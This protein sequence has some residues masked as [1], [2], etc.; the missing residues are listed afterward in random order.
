M[1]VISLAIAVEKLKSMQSKFQS[2]II[3]LIEKI[4][5][6]HVDYYIFIICIY[7]YINEPYDHKVQLP[8]LLGDILE[9]D[10]MM[11]Y[12]IKKEF[13]LGNNYLQQLKLVKSIDEDEFHNGLTIALSDDIIEQLENEVEVVNVAPKTFKELIR[14]NEKDIPTLFYNDDV[15]QEIDR[16]KKILEPKRFKELNDIF[17]LNYL[18]THLNILLAGISGSGKSE[19]AKLLSINKLVYEVDVSNWKSSFYGESQKIVQQH[20]NK[21]RKMAE[22]NP[23]ECVMLLN[24][25]DALIGKRLSEVSAASDQTNN[26]I[27]NIILMNIEKLGNGAILIATTNKMDFLDEAF[28]RRFMIK[29]NIGTPNVDTSIKIW[30]HYLSGYPDNLYSRLS[31]LNLSGGLISIICRKVIM[32]KLVYS[33]DVSEDTIYSWAFAESDFSKSSMV[34]VRGFQKAS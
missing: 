26:A 13:L 12:Q 21:F 18:P 24:E 31:T 7:D 3:D 22:K 5:L 28:A 15:Q 10:S 30:K 25:A 16:L 6:N 4:A 29:L 9:N 33:N 2:P 27:Q 14:I 1:G 17:K 20:F 8:R 34:N 32:E 19:L 23:F 11:L